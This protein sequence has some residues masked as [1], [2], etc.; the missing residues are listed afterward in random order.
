MEAMS[1]AIR[2]H[3]MTKIKVK[4]TIPDEK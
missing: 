1:S 3:E 2:K 4:I